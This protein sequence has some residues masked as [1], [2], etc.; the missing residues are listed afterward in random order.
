MALAALQFRGKSTSSITV[1]FM[2][3]VSRSYIILGS[4]IRWLFMCQD[5][6]HKL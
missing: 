4:S 1:G 2:N 6:S 5:V 3:I